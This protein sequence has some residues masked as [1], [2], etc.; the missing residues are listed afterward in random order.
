MTEKKL[1]NKANTREYRKYEFCEN[2]GCPTIK[3]GGK[4]RIE[5]SMCWCTAKEFHHWLNENG[6]KIVKEKR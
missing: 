6:F 3:N 2:V 4:C 5:P 1:N